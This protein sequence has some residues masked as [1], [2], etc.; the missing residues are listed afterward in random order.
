MKNTEEYMRAVRSHL[1]AKHGKMKGEWL[2]GLQMLEDSINIYNQCVEG[3]EKDGLLIVNRNGIIGKN[4]LI[5]IKLDAEK[6]INRTLTEFGL[7]P[8]S[9]GK[10]QMEEIETDE[11]KDLFD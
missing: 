1:R 8:K 11:L 10:I 7:T 2:Q 5:Q 4:P 9:G 3:I 6:Q